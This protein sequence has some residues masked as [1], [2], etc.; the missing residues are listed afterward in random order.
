MPWPTLSTMRAYKVLDWLARPERLDVA[1]RS[2]GVGYDRPEAESR[3][4]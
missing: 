2:V 4:N 3:I 1:L